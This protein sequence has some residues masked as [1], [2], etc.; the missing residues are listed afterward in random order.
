[1]YPLPVEKDSIYKLAEC[2]KR[3]TDYFY[4][5]GIIIYIEN[6]G[7]LD[8]FNYLPEDLKLVFDYS[9]KT[10]L[11]LDIAHIDSYE[12]LYKII[13]IKYPKMLHIADRHFSV[14]HEHLPI[15]NGD[16]DFGLIFSEYLSDFNGKVIFEIT[17]EDNIIIDSMAK[18]QKAM[19]QNRR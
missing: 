14:E 10:E 8:P 17:E 13:E 2:N 18:I 5:N 12:H 1:M 15:G 11:L 19:Y 6:N 4:D 9:P 3:L 7:R 16:I